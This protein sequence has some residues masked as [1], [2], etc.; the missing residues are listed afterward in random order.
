MNCEERVGARE[1]EEFQGLYGPFMVHETMVQRIWLRGEFDRLQ[2][3]TLDGEPVEVLDPGEWNRQ[4]GPDFL[5]ARLKIGRRLAEGD[6][7]VHFRLRHWH[8]HNHSADPAYAR[9]ILHVVCFPPGAAEADRPAVVENRT[10]PTLVLLDLL[11]R[12]LEDYA[13][14]EAIA[15]LAGTDFGALAERLLQLDGAACRRALTSA[16][17]RRW[18]EKVHYAGLRID[19]LGWREAC[20][21]TALEILGYRS[22]RSP[23]LEA[24]A[25]FPLAEWLGIGLEPSTVLEQ[26]RTAWT[27]RGIRPANRPLERL[28]QYREW[29]NR[30]GCWPER[31]REVVDVLRPGEIPP[32]LPPEHHARMARRELDLPG[33]ERRLA[34]EVTGGAVGGKRLHNLITDG[35]LPLAT[36]ADGVDR[37][38]WWFWWQPGD[39]PDHL[40]RALRDAG[41]FQQR[42]EAPANGWQQGGFGLLL[43]ERVSS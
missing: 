35:F 37:F 11:W 5:G 40:S 24:A 29:V 18:Q 36:A 10:I 34:E 15:A 12:D 32:P 14:D 19:R 26:V 25:R 30:A 8:D 3:R 4:A 21:Q 17:R 13:A 2:A 31:L 41:L 22:N 6:V 16:A 28:R 39:A 38:A 7:E 1:A 43:Q 33:L 42:G 9:V 20:H 27:S 23:M